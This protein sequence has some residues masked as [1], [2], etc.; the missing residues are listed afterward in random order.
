MNLVASETS[1]AHSWLANLGKEAKQESD[2]GASW[3]LFLLIH[4][5]QTAFDWMSLVTPAPLCCVKAHGESGPS[6]R[7]RQPCAKA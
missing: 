3:I 4:A 6:T 2:P 1:V 5:D 7:P